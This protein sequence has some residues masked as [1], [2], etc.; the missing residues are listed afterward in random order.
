VGAHAKMRE[1]G[2]PVSRRSTLGAKRYVRRKIEQASKADRSG[3]SAVRLWQVKST[4]PSGA[5]YRITR[6]GVQRSP[7]RAIFVKKKR[8]QRD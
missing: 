6:G 7:M 2:V 8:S 1:S 4:A 5:V 3:S